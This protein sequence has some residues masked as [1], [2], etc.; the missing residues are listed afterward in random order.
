MPNS[1]SEAKS[2]G[3]IVQAKGGSLLIEDVQALTNANQYRLYQLIRHKHRM[4]KDGQ[5][6]AGTEVRIMVTSPVSFSALAQ[7]VTFRRELYYLLGALVVEIPSLRERK[8]DLEHK[9][10]ETLRDCCEHY[11]RYHVLTKGA[12]QI[13][14]DYPWN[15]NLIQVENFCE[16]LILTAQKRSLDE[17][18]VEWLLSEM[19]PGEEKEKSFDDVI[20]E[21]E[22]PYSIEAKEIRDTLL[23]LGGSR[24]RT[25]KE[26]G[27][28]KATLWRKMKKY[29]LE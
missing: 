23:K 6:Y 16:R 20:S 13:L 8:E 22:V 7:E 3:A 28:S 10:R 11:S 24:E 17:A 14:L 4:G 19:Y 15:G 1:H 2:G 29:H 21:Q 5:R 26:L 25:A 9:I 12:F 27:I 18:F